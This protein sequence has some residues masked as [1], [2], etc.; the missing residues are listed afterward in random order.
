[1]ASEIEVL[2]GTVFI[3]QSLSFL[4]YLILSLHSLCSFP[5]VHVLPRSRARTNMLIL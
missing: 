5:L 4:L 2:N 3:S 1:M